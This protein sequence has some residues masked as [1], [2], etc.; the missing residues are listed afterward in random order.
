MTCSSAQ[1][2]GTIAGTQNSQA[3]F[4]NSKTQIVG[5]SF[6]CDFS[7]FNAILWENGSMVDLNALI[8]T[9]S[10]FHL[11]SASFIDDRGEIAAYGFLNNFDTH[12]LL[13][14]PCDESH[15]DS[16]CK[17]VNTDDALRRRS[18]RPNG[19]LPENI[20]NM[21]RDHQVRRGTRLNPAFVR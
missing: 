3:S 17:N 19:I 2:L 13:L 12:A 21:L 4:I 1:S 8:P 16:E 15:D 7:V 10:P 20:R 9:N 11:Y 5:L 6:G 14:I 18:Q